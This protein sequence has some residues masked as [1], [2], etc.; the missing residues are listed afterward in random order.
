VSFPAALFK[1]RDVELMDSPTVFT[2]ASTTLP[3]AFFGTL[4]WIADHRCIENAAFSDIRR[5]PL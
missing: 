4:H 2:V 1:S 3:V 5:A